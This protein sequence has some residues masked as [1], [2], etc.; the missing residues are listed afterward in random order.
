MSESTQS[1]V[2][3]FANGDNDPELFGS[4]LRH[5]AGGHGFGFLD[6]E[7][8]TSYSE[9]PLDR[10]NSRIELWQK[11]GWWANVDFTNDPTQVKWAKYLTDDRY[12][13][14]VGIYQGG[15]TYGYGVYKPTENSMM[16]ENMEYFNAPSR[17]AIYKRIVTLSGEGYT[18]D[19]FLEYD[20]VNRTAATR[21]VGAAKAPARRDWQPGAPPVIHP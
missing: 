15:S 3:F 14:D 12:K 1:S 7:Y 13:N 9:I 5:E 21:S 2:A 10:K 18:Y 4:T 16:N 17:E 8:V 20:A 19:K 6:D 11:Y